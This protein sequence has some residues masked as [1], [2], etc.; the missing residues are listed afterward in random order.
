MEKSPLGPKEYSVGT[1]TKNA[2][3]VIK[4]QGSFG[5]GASRVVY[6][7]PT[8]SGKLIKEYRSD[9]KDEITILERKKD[10]YLSKLLHSLFP[11]NVPNIDMALPT[12]GI[13]V[14]DKIDEDKSFLKN[15]FLKPIQ[16]KIFMLKAYELGFRFDEND[17][18][19]MLGKSG[20]VKYVDSS[21]FYGNPEKI[22]LFIEKN[23]PEDKK[24][25]AVEYLDN[26]EKYE[27]LLREQVKNN[28]AA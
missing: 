17:S 27:A 5:D 20:K 4:K 12:H 19:F 11:D 10:F 7:H 26:Y 22:K 2:L 23:L 1:R 21:D 18:N 8:E 14:F 3:E 15:K 6:D 24:S 25:E 16:K 9:K 13:E 28:L